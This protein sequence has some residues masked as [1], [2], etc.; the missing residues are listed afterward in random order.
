MANSRSPHSSGPDKEEILR[1]MKNDEWSSSDWYDTRYVVCDEACFALRNP[2]T[3]TQI[4]EAYRHWK[5]HKNA[6]GCAHGR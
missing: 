4:E 6:Y 1:R 3:P 5:D 2:V